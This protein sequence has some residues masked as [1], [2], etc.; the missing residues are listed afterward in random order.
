MSEGIR[1]ELAGINLGDKRLNRRSKTVIE[2]L[3]AKPE[4]SINAACNGW[5]ETLATYRF[6]DNASVSPEEILL[7][8]RAA[9]ERRMREHPVVL[10]VQDTTELDYTNHP[11]VDA[12][13]LNSV[14]RFGLYLHAHLA[15]TPDKLCLGV[16]GV[17]CFDRAPETIGLSHQRESLPIEMKESFR[18]LKGYR[19]ACDLAATCQETQIVNIADREADIYEIFVEAQQAGP[20]SDYIIRAKDDRCTPERNLEAGPATYKKVRDEVSRSKR[21]TTRT[22]DLSQ[23]PKR[24]G[25]K[26]ILEIRAIAVVLKPPHSRARLHLSPVTHNV[27]LI[28]EVGHPSDGTHV[29]WLLITTLPIE[30]PE[31]LLLILDYYVARWTVEIFFRTLKTGCKVEDIQLETTPRLKRCL[32]LYLIIAWRVLHLTYLNRTAPTIPCT[33]M[34]AESEW[35]A[36]WCVVTKLPP[37]KTPPRLSEIMRMLTQLGGY[38]N[39]ANEAPA[40]P[41]TIWCG[42]RR[43]ID[44]AAAWVA[45]G[46][47]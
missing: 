22:I 36:V 35:K 24:M 4:A 5:N 12:R 2:T 40:G 17:E 32:S 44:F 31:D 26:A 34:F 21:R 13:C 25:R 41:Q 7:P 10:I 27:V 18:W 14:D 19:L 46:P 6:F 11:P 3:A 20:R 38:N 39:R 1:E 42:M 37:P 30:T 43:M 9:T 8:H 47:E 28:E 16:V 23:T 15:V 45:F 33:A 29:S